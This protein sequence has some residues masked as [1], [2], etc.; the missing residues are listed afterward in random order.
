MWACS[1]HALCGVCACVLILLP[2]GRGFMGQCLDI[3]ALD[4]ASA[5]GGCIPEAV[6]TFEPG[7]EALGAW[8]EVKGE[9][10][11]VNEALYTGV[12][13]GTVRLDGSRRWFEV[14]GCG[15]DGVLLPRPHRK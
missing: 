2:I 3:G 6:V 8:Q 11:S 14:D 9:A 5:I 15:C 13:E 4:L 1:W 12:I 7:E 10:M